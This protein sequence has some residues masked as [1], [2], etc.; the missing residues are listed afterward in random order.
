MSGD[1]F[2]P[3]VPD[4]PSKRAG[5]YARNRHRYAANWPARSQACKDAAGWRCE[6]CDAPHGPPPHILTVDHL[7]HDVENPDAALVA[8]CQRCHLARQGLRPR[9]TDKADA[10]RRLLVWNQDRGYLPNPRQ[11]RRLL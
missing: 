6:A 4:K 11:P 9:P 10:L 8:L 7:D 3:I 2:F 5:W 1:V